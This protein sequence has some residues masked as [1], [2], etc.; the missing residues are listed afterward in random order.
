MR[1][2]FYAGTAQGARCVLASPEEWRALRS[3]GRRPPCLG[4]GDPCPFRSRL[5][6]PKRGALWRLGL[7]FGALYALW[8]LHRALSS[9]SALVRWLSLSE[10]ALVAWGL[11]RW[12]EGGGG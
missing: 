4:G 8:L 9:E 6:P 11:R 10:L 5:D 1:C 7:L 2:P 12:W 3:N